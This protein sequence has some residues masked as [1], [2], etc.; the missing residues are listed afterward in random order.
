MVKGI[1]YHRLDDGDVVRD[2]SQV[3]E[4]LRKLSAALTVFGEFELRSEQFGVWIDKCRAV[5][6]Q[7]LRRRK[8]SVELGQ[9]GL[10]IK[11]FQVAGSTGHEKKNDSL[12]LWNQWWFPGG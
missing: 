12:G 3:R 10:I 4:Q 8:C 5:S 2:L 9:L 6:L 7:Q 1:R 11:Q